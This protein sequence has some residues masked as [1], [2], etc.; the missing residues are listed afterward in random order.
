MSIR[1]LNSGS[2][3]IYRLIWPCCAATQQLGAGGGDAALAVLNLSGGG[4]SARAAGRPA[5]DQYVLPCNRRSPERKLPR[6]RRA[7]AAVPARTPAARHPPLPH[8]RGPDLS[9]AVAAKVG[10]PAASPVPPIIERNR[11]TPELRRMTP[12]SCTTSTLSFEVM[13]IIETPDCVEPPKT[14]TPPTLRGFDLPRGRRIPWCR[15]QGAAA[16]R[17]GGWLASL[18]LILLF[19]PRF[20]EC[21]SPLRACR[22]CSCSRIGGCRRP[23]RTWNFA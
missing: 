19:S 7:R 9:L 10:H 8:F 16:G 6:R 5:V 4:E 17:A 22:S 20:S 3:W 2:I 15:R 23:Q 11:G 21:R 12:R 18:S 13:Q 1:M 14:C